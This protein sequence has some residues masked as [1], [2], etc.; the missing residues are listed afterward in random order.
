M[1]RPR[2]LLTHTTEMR[3]NYYGEA[4][5]AEL[6]RLGDVALHDGALPLDTDGVVTLARGCAL[7]VADRATALPAAVFAGLPELVAVCRV[8]VDIR[9]IDVDAASRA[10]ILVCQAGRS[11]VPAVAE[12]AIGL[13]I[14]AA[15]GISRAN[16]AWKGGVAPSVAMGRQL[17]GATVGIIGFGPLGRR[18]A[19]LALAFGMRVLAHDPYAP[20]DLAGVEARDRAS[21]LA[22]ADFIL[23]LAVA[24][25]ETEN[26]IDAA[27]LAAMKPDAFL[28]NLARGNLV[29]EVALAAALDQGRIAGAAM[30]VG[31]APDQMPSLALARRGDVSATPHVGGLTRAA[32][33]VQAL[34]TVAQARELL[35]GRAPKGAVNADR[36]TRAP[37]ATWMDRTP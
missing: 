24:T 34:E 3:H 9:N 25:P 36:W 35:V 31:R 33:E 26:M 20:I 30:D 27:A 32:V 6:A 2:I 10:G 22:C 16:I 28:I 4:A 14:D 1:T 29:D 23:P 13:M 18:V 15:R 12:L 8:A 5:L 21:L 17:H 7:I 11:W 37:A 19:E